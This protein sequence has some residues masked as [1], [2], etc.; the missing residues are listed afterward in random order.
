[1]EGNPHNSSKSRVIYL[2]PRYEER[3]EE[4][5][6]SRV[7]RW[8]PRMDVQVH[9]VDVRASWVRDWACGERQGT[10]ED[11]RRAAARDGRTGVRLRDC[12]C[13]PEST[14]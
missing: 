14:G 10:Q 11:V 8:N 7:T 3:V 13:S 12:H 6:E 4:V 9:R 1:M 5:F 2:A